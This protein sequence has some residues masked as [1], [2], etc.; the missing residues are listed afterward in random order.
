M[1]NI[2]HI[3]SEVKEEVLLEYSIN[4]Q[5]MV[6]ESSIKSIYMQG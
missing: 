5:V 3:Q 4:R 2:K 6:L 1:K